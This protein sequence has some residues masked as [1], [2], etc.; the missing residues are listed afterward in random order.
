MKSVWHHQYYYMFGFLGVI[1][2]VLLIVCI[3]VTLLAIYWTLSSE[4]RGHV[5]SVCYVMFIG[6][7]GE[8]FILSVYMHV[9]CVFYVIQCM[10]FI[11][12]ACI[13]YS[14]LYLLHA[15]IIPFLSFSFLVFLTLFLG[16]PLV[17]ARVHCLRLLHLLPLPLHNLLLLCP[18]AHACRHCPWH[19]LLCP[20]DHR[21]PCLCG[22]YG[23]G[24]LPCV[25]CAAAQ[26]L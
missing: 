8:S 21:L 5:E 16:V 10:H 18:D 20:R 12:F 22:R 26:D 4:V 23:V 7:C 9:V 3:E 11:W 6:A 13:Y 14:T 17:V 15:Y 2:C 25:L 1:F 24:G 19:H